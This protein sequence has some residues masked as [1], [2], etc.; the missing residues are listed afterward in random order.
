MPILFC[1]ILLTEPKASVIMIP[2]LQLVLACYF[3]C[4]S[5][6]YCVRLSNGLTKVGMK[7]WIL[8]QPRT[9]TSHHPLPEG[10]CSFLE[11]EKER[12]ILKEKEILRTTRL[13]SRI[14]LSHRNL[15]QAKSFFWVGKYGFGF[16]CSTTSVI[17][18]VL[19]L[20][21]MRAATLILV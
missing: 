7:S 17:S 9:I 1:S 16:F 15:H 19:V 6:A 13:L 20:V 21:K 8:I 14:S 2:F 11:S 4:V 3:F 10:L 18:F 5:S 12:K